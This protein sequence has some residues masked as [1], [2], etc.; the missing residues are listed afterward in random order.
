MRW[1]GNAADLLSGTLQGLRVVSLEVTLRRPADVRRSHS[2]Q[3]T[4]Y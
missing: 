3:V 4:I 1:G 2:V